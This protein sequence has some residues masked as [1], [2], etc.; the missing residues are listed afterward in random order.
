MRIGK[1]YAIV[2]AIGL[3]ACATGPRTPE[4]TTADGPTAEDGRAACEQTIY[5]TSD[6]DA[7]T[8]LR[9]AQLLDVWN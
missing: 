5:R 7:S 2:T 3:S 6:Y 9:C 4:L 1:L 8:A